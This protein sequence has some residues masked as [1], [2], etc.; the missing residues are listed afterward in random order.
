MKL[1]D[2]GLA[3]WS[4][5]AA[6]P[7]ADVTEPGVVLGTP[8]YMAPEQ[9]RG[10]PA[11]ARTDIFALGAILYEMMA[12][13]APFAHAGDAERQAAILRDDP[14]A[15]PSTVPAPLR[16]SSSGASKTTGRTLSVRR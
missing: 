10:E 2:F 13:R 3:R 7:G 14:P 15:L 12:G 16:V 9:V 1:L 8:R 5:A 4:D 11:D 6:Q